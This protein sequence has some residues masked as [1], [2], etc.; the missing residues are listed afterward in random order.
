MTVGTRTSAVSAPGQEGSALISALVF[1]AVGITILTLILESSQ[2]SRRNSRVQTIDVDRNLMQEL[3]L[4]TVLEN[5]ADFCQYLQL[6]DWEVESIPPH[7]SLD[8]CK[9]HKPQ[10]LPALKG[11]IAKKDITKTNPNL[12]YPFTKNLQKFLPNHTLISFKLDRKSIQHTEN[13]CENPGLF[14]AKVDAEIQDDIPAGLTATQGGLTK[15]FTIDIIFGKSGS[16]DEID[17]KPFDVCRIPKEENSM[18]EMQVSA[19][20]KESG[21]KYDSLHRKCEL[22]WGRCP[23]GEAITHFVDGKITCAPMVHG[24]NSP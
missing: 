20:C 15:H 19:I 22:Q 10:P 18:R 23:A 8:E 24:G 7:P 1:G 4:G 16:W 3:T 11:F 5:G 13:A 9:E 21:G 14:S 2:S 12:I 17:G 6:N